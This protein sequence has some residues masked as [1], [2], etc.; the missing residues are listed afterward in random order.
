MQKVTDGRPTVVLDDEGVTLWLGDEED[1]RILWTQLASV[2][3]G[4]VGA[5]EMVYFEAFWGL[6]GDGA[7]V[8]V[9]VELIVNSEL[10]NE[11]LFQLP[12]FDME[13][14]RKAREAEAQGLIE[15]FTCWR[16]SNA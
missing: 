6:T 13:M 10:L 11:R 15:E 3:I 2:E 1:S 16:K 9:P 5:P 12:G 14:Y 8:V 4:I 7:Q